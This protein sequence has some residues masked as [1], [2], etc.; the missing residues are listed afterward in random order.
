M[1]SFVIPELSVITF[2]EQLVFISKEVKL[3]WHHMPSYTKCGPL[4]QLRGH[5]LRGC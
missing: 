5:D 3:D 4:D 1:L 2:F